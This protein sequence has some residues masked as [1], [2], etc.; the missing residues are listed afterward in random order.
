MNLVL[1]CQNA[2]PSI[3][4]IVKLTP[5]N[6]YDL[7]H[8]GR[9]LCSAPVYHELRRQAIAQWDEITTLKYAS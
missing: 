2:K 9:N 3:D 6:R 1:L 5:G 8:P 4:Y 7:F